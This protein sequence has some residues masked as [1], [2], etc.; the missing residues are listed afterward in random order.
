MRPNFDGSEANP[1]LNY[2]DNSMVFYLLSVL[3]F[4]KEKISEVYNGLFI[5]FDLEPQLFLVS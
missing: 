5:T 3:L 4:L 1:S 2:H